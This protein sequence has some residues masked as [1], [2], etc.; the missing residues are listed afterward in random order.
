[1][2]SL[3]CSLAT[4]FM[5]LGPF[6]EKKV[7]FDQLLN[8]HV[9]SRVTAPAIRHFL[10]GN[11][12]VVGPKDGAE[13][14]YSFHNIVE[15]GLPR[16]LIRREVVEQKARSLWEAAGKPVGLDDKFW[17]DACGHIEAAMARANAAA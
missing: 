8:F 1:M 17:L 5:R 3:S 15:S 12:H 7:S 11:Y 16:R 13:W 9:Y 4:I 2:N 6:F 10:A 14:Y